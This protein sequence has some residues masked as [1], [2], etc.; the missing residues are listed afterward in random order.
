MPAN[1]L[2][3]LIQ[4]AQQAGD[5]ARSFVG[6]DLGVEYKTHD[7][8]PVTKADYAVNAALEDH[9]RSARPDYGWLSEESAD[10]QDRLD[11]EHVFI[12][13]PIDGTRSFIAGE[14]T[15]AHSLAVARNGEITAAVVFLPMLDRLY[16]ASL[17]G[18][19]R[20]NGTPLRVG[21]RQELS[22]AQ[23]LA[24]R[25]SMEDQH[26]PN[27]TPDI[28]RHHRPSL[29]YRL[30]LVAQGRFDAMFTFRPSWEWDIAAGALILLEAGATTTDKTG[31]PLRFN[32]AH[33]QTNG[34]LTANAVLHAALLT[35]LR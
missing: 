32:N 35:R 29:A 25:P 33:P 34:V 11:C 14:K 18:G 21:T 20:V 3:L 30:S 13:D 22:G 7:D 1:D 15:W 26:W 2:A 17:G 19:A 4:A 31:A 10:S 16:T 8:S 27:G 9:L 6:G 5:I 12:V 23:V 24:T 28:E